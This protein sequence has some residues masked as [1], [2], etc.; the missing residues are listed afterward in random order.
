MQTTARKSSAE[1]T[2]F[3]LETLLLNAENSGATETVA[4]IL[5]NGGL[6]AIPTETVYGLA[7]NAFDPVACAN[8]FKAKGR[9]GDNPLIVHIC[10]M[11]MLKDVVEEVPEK[12][13]I[14]AEKFWPGPLTMIMKKSDKIPM[15][16]SANLPT[17]AVRFPAHPVAQRIIA[18]AG[19]PLAAPSANLS[20]SPSPT[21]FEHCVHDLLGRVDAIIDGGPCAVGVE[22]TIISFAEETPMLL[23]PGYVTLEQLRGAI[24]EVGLSKAVL[25]KLGDGEKVLSPGMKYKHYAPKA[26]V[27]LVKGSREQYVKYVNE[28]ADEHGVFA[29]CFDEEAPVLK[30]STVCYGSEYSD[31]E[32]AERLFDALRELDELGALRVYAHSPRT[33][34]VGMAVYNR[35]VRAAGFDIITLD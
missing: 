21:T 35:L 12:A 28:H 34:G 27:S 14:L 2:D 15:V 32:Q 6:A 23:R 17:V 11:D 33:T 13:K 7:A 20:G 8:I 1:R 9:P 29:L 26:K 25:E 24:G 5:K 18:E 31:A 4:E 10:N 3:I 16:T 22:S 30:T 19:L